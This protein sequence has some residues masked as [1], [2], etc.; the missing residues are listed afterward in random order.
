MQAKRDVMLMCFTVVV[1]ACGGSTLVDSHE[2][3]QSTYSESSTARSLEDLQSAIDERV[4]NLMASGEI[5]GLSL[6]V[7]YG[8]TEQITK[9]YGVRRLET[10]D[11]VTEDTLFL[12]A[13]TTKAITASVLLQTMRQNK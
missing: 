8:D 10:E 4:Q 12:L 9:G 2:A 11:N 7:V 13:S 3:S 6:A 1:I 5:P